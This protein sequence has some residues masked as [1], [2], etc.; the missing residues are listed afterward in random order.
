M[1]TSF[2][3]N[4]KINTYFQV[5]LSCTAVHAMHMFSL[6]LISMLCLASAVR[7]LSLGFSLVRSFC[8]HLAMH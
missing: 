4:P 7:T 3:K 6:G 5:G 1:C 2:L 8:G